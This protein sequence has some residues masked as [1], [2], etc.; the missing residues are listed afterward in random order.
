MPGDD[1][2]GIRHIEKLKE[3]FLKIRKSGFAEE[4]KK[5]LA[6]LA[7]PVLDADGFLLG[8]IGAYAPLFRF[9]REKKAELIN[10]LKKASQR[11]IQ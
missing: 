10:A 4:K 6:A 3:E 5:E 8:A 11:I 1:W 2:N 7:V 9:N